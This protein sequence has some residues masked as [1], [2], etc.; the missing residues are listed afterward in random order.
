MPNA[1]RVRLPDL[2]HINAFLD[3]G[4]ALGYV[5]EFLGQHAGR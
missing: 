5:S 1:T 4:Q 2:E 3:S